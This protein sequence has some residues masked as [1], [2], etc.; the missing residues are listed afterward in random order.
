VPRNI[1]LLIDITC[2]GFSFHNQINLCP[3]VAYF[4]S[5]R[6]PSVYQNSSPF[7][8]STLSLHA[9]NTNNQGKGSRWLA[10][11]KFSKDKLK[12]PLEREAHSITKSR[13]FLYGNKTINLSTQTPD[14]TSKHPVLTISFEAAR[15][16]RD[17]GKSELNEGQKFFH[18]AVGSAD[19][20]NVRILTY[21]M[22]QSPS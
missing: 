19:S 20:A 6:Q 15:S 11:L 13:K 3:G 21:S 5:S 16:G 8:T 7:C 12:F 1:S 9:D 18:T 4:Q 14:F 17:R 2:S 10:N 22:V